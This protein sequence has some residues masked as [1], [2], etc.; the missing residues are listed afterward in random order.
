MCSSDLLSRPP[1]APGRTSPSPNKFNPSQPPQTPRPRTS[2][3]FAAA[4]QVVGMSNPLSNHPVEKK[5]AIGPMQRAEDAIPMP[6]RPPSSC[7]ATQKTLPAPCLLPRARYQQRPQA[8]RTLPLS[9]QSQRSVSSPSCK[10]T[11]SSACPPAEPPTW[12]PSTSVSR[13]EALLHVSCK[14]G[15]SRLTHPRCRRSRTECGLCH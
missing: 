10:S 13:Q 14:W 5:E 4:Y 6:L 3:P 1:D 15:R 11:P 8:R 2:G 12:R 9:R 7:G